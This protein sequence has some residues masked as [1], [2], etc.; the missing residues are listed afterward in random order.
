MADSPP[1]RD[2]TRTRASGTE[3]AVRSVLDTSASVSRQRARDAQSFV[4]MDDKLR[5]ECD[6][7]PRDEENADD[8]WRAGSDGVGEL[9][10]FC[11]VCWEREFGEADARP[12]N[13][14]ARAR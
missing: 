11:P 12:C 7:L 2:E 6:R 5:C 13:S 8:E 3:E 14:E 1:S 4:Q 10:V 9:H